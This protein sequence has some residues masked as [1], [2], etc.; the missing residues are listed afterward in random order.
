MNELIEKALE[1]V[2][3]E[4]LLIDKL[5][6]ADEKDKTIIL[7]Q[8]KIKY[9]NIFFDTNALV[10][11]M[12][13]NYPQDEL[14]TTIMSG[15]SDLD[16]DTFDRST[17]C[18]LLSNSYREKF[19]ETVFEEE[20][21]RFLY[22]IYLWFYKENRLDKE[23]KESLHKFINLRATQSILLRNY[24]AGEQSK[25]EEISN[26]E[27]TYGLLSNPL[28]LEEYYKILQRVIHDSNCTEIYDGEEGYETALEGQRQYLAL[29]FTA[30]C[31]E[32]MVR[33][34]EFPAVEEE[35]S[36]FTKEILKEA[37][38]LANKFIIVSGMKKT[39]FGLI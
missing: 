24:F 38:L 8:L 37:S 10:D 26:P 7:D 35:I 33:G 27:A 16:E 19:K 18:F 20:N 3:E 31:A 9:R 13:E 22:A 32:M 36:E 5:I 30:I 23:T 11:Y 34:I 4:R 17:L 25:L 1:K 39:R 15:S 12:L 2:K 29:E 6:R 14:M 28:A 21:N